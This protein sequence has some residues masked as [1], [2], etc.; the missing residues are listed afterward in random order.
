MH[1]P[2][3]DMLVIP[4]AAFTADRELPGAEKAPWGEIEMMYTTIIFCNNRPRAAA[5][6]C[7]WTKRSVHAYWAPE[8]IAG[9]PRC[10]LLNI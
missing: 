4:G 1:T 7:F 8:A 9:A 5:H 10:L 2:Q 3:E 6:R